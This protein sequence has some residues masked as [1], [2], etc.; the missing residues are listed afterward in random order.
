MILPA[1]PRFDSLRRDPRFL[2]LLERMSLPRP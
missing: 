1:D 2:A